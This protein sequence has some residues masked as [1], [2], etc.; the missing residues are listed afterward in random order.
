[1][2]T[3]SADT[4]GE[5]IRHAREEAGL[6]QVDLGEACGVRYQTVQHWE[7]DNALPRTHLMRVIE[8]TLN[9]EP[10]T[11]Y[12]WLDHSPKAGD[13]PPSARGKRCFISHAGG[14]R[15]HVHV[16]LPHAPHALA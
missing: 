8:R 1:M 2:A 16:T 7:H 11:L 12:A 14:L 13:H 5:R 3:I 4:F 6:R 15:K 10:G 9:L